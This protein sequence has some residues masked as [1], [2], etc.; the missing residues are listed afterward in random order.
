MTINIKNNAQLFID[1][2]RISISSV[3]PSVTYIK[4]KT[5]NIL[6]ISGKQECYPQV[7]TFLGA[8]TK[9]VKF[10]ADNG[11]CKLEY[12]VL[13]TSR[14]IILEA[15]FQNM[16]DTPINLCEFLMFKS[17]EN[18]L[19]C[20]GNPKEWWMS[21][22]PYCA[23]SG[24]LEDKLESANEILEKYWKAF[25]MPVP[26]KMSDA[27]LHCDGRWRSYTDYLT[28][29][30]QKGNV[31]MFVG[32]EGKPCADLIFHSFVDNGK[33]MLSILSD[34]TNIEVLPGQTRYAQ[35]V[36][37]LFEPYQL[38]THTLLT[39]IAQTHGSRT[40]IP[41][42]TGW[43]S[44]YDL[45][46]NITDETISKTTDAIL[47]SDFSIEVI[48]VDDGFQKTVGDWSYNS[49]FPNGLESFVKKVKS[50]GVVPGIWLAPLAVHESTGIVDKNSHWFQHDKNGDLLGENNNWGS[51][52]RWLDPT[53]P[54]AKEFIREI[55]RDFVGQGFKYFKIDF[56][57]L[58]SEAYYFDKS[59]TRLEI[60][61]DLYKLYREEIGEDSYLL[62]CSGLQRGTV[63]YVDASRI[64]PDTGFTWSADHNCTILEAI[65]TTG[66][67]AVVNGIF[68]ANDPDVT[69]LRSVEPEKKSSYYDLSEDEL[70]TWHSFMGLLGGLVLISEPIEKKE[71]MEKKRMFD[72]LCPPSKD[73]GISFDF[74]TSRNHTQFGT[75]SQRSYGDFA[76]ILLWND[77]EIPSDKKLSTTGLEM[78]EAPYYIWSFW[79]KK[80]MGLYKEEYATPQLEPHSCQVIRITPKN[81]TGLPQIIGSDLHI[82]CGGA[83]IS[84][85]RATHD[86]LEIELTNAGAD[87]GNIFFTAKFVPNSISGIGCIIRSVEKISEEI[88]CI[89][90]SGRAKSKAQIITIKK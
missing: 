24:S 76:T 71:V 82:S 61:R 9:N 42:V 79:D 3:S 7:N 56:N 59:K 20:E 83:D 51:K 48:Q 1:T 33:V 27:P 17:K 32:P 58:N 10:R 81:T 77:K 66:A 4:N 87:E 85:V 57:S 86:S 12:S 39:H 40:H 47:S 15:T 31:G 73:K 70:I 44:W 41:P 19:I 68:Y 49:K 69:Y 34:M 35:S 23:K 36:A 84:D 13:T 60:Y 65:R 5:K 67:T 8:T 78:I 80:Y 45:F 62:S 88:Y 28:L 22:L 53:H 52:G 21:S 50:N 14:G 55:I 18:G 16:L 72:I 30:T 26:I 54:E 64:G 74:G 46:A 75:I 90:I 6:E 29:Y 11:D 2:E 43:C 25:G 38:A 37:I 63:G 89:S